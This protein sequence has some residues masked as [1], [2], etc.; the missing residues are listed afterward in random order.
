[1]NIAHH[2][3]IAKGVWY[4]IGQTSMTIDKTDWISRNVGPLSVTKSQS[5]AKLEGRGGMPAW[6]NQQLPRWHG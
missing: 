3:V 4:L 5:A 2:P 6:F 1:M